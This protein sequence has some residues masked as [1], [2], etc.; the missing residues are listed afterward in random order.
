MPGKLPL[1]RPVRFAHRPQARRAF[2]VAI[3][4]TEKVALQLSKILGLEPPGGRA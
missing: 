3:E 1:Q 4:W 2:A